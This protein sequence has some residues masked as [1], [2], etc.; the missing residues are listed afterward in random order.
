MSSLA[1]VAAAVLPAIVLMRYI[2]KHDRIESEPIGLLMRLLV[3]GGLSILP[4]ILLETAGQYFFALFLP[5]KSL[6]YA[7]L[8]MFFVVAPAEEGC[9]YF[10]LKRRTWKHPAF[11]YRFDGVVYAVFVSLGFAALENI[12]YVMQFGLSVALTRAIFSIPAHMGFAVFMGTFYGRAKVCEINGDWQG[13]RH[14]TR[15]ALFVPMLFHGFFNACLTL[16]TSASMLV[17]IGF[18]VA[19]YIVVI[20]KIKRE[21][22]ADIKLE[23][24][25]DFSEIEEDLQNRR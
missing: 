18:T 8:L 10:F 9:K 14:N 2:Y 4:A 17:F 11:N 23:T 15:A 20:R 21:A 22:I 13:V 19:M 25:L 24:M 3:A 5:P 7:V 6:I 1:F 16:E 12:G